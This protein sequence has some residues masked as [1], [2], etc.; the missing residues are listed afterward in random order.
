[1]TPYESPPEDRPTRDDEE[2]WTDPRAS[3]VR[4]QYGCP[5]WFHGHDTAAAVAHYRAHGGGGGGVSYSGSQARYQHEL[6][7]GIHDPLAMLPEQVALLTRSQREDRVRALI[8]QS[9]DILSQAIEEHVWN[10]GRMVAATVVLFSGGNDSTT[11][12]HLFRQEAD[13]FAHANTTIGIEETRDFVRNVSEEFGVS[14]IERKPPRESDRY[15]ALVLDQGFPGPAMHFK[16]FT[17]LKERALEQ[18]QSELVNNPYKERVVFI[19]GR[20]RT[21]SER[22]KRVPAMQ[23]KGSRVYASPLVNWTKL[24][25]NTYRLMHQPR[26]DWNDGYIGRCDISSCRCHGVPRNKASDLIHMSGE[27]LCGAFAAPGERDEIDQWFP[28]ALDE[29]RELEALIADRDDI[30]EHRKTWGW[31]ADPAKKALDGAPSKSGLLCSS[32]DDRF[33]TALDFGGAA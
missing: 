11:L 32:C 20:R 28:L 25:L 16:M 5:S 23:R 9:R 24:D 13:Y 26:A 12:A 31:G 21:E 29:V 1:M 14:L 17:R 15:R 30:P 4:C 33:Q 27:C 18:I 2:H 8:E 22:R 19:A 10:D 7:L 6:E 3:M